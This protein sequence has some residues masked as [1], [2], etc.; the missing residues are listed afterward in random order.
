MSICH[1]LKMMSVGSQQ[2][3][4]YY[5][6]MYTIGTVKMMCCETENSSAQGESVTDSGR[7]SQATDNVNGCFVLWQMVPRM[8]SLELVL[9]SGNKVMA[10]M[11]TILS[12]FALEMLVPGHAVGKV[13]GRGRSNVDNIRKTNK[14]IV[15]QVISA[16]IARDFV[17]T[18]AYAHD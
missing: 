3:L 18:S 5:K 7:G 10:V 11:E 14:D 12:F 1:C 2:Q 9:S 6:N 16:T 15:A 8:W 13:M 4:G 17:L